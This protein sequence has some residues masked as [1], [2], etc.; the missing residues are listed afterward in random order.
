[1]PPLTKIELAEMIA[2]TLSDAS[3]GFAVVHGLESYPQSLGRDLDILIS[4]ASIPR[5]LAVVEKALENVQCRL[6]VHHRFSGDRWCFVEAPDSTTVFEFD[7]IS[8]LRWGPCILHSSPVVEGML[9]P[10]PLD[11]VA[12]FSKAVFLQLLGGSAEKAVAR[13]TD[14]SSSKENDGRLEKFLGSN[15]GQDMATEVWKGLRTGDA[16]G[17]S[18]LRPFIK[19][20]LFANGIQAGTKPLLSAVRHW[21]MN[22]LS[23]SPF[24][25]PIAPSI[26]FV[27]PDGV[28][29]STVI[30]LV[31]RKVR[32]I[33]PIN[34]VHLRH[35]RPQL[36]PPLGV[37][38]GK[39]IPK[40]GAANPPRRNAGQF[41]LVRLLYYGFDFI[42]GSWLKDRPRLAFNELVIYDRCLLDMLVD[43]LRFGL[44][45]TRGVELIHKITRKHD[46]VILLQDSPE[47]IFTRKPELSIDEIQEQYVVW[48]RLYKEGKIHA[49]INVAAGPEETSESVVSLIHN[50]ALNRLQVATQ[51][52]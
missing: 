50:A 11:L 29:K 33:L 14:I 35:W 49:I 20:R 30:D 3:I 1:M 51:G 10:F 23:L 47:R 8:M 34:G 21:V 19:R 42:V 52:S 9:G 28:G 16:R 46:L 37:F 6:M 17:L 7:F 25:T 39:T 15:L 13:M 22:E 36:V 24:S 31:G 27:G 40:V 32:K 12:N 18:E 38:L 41:S 5:A 44:P 2:V 48:E 26:A 45:S 43:P 4:A